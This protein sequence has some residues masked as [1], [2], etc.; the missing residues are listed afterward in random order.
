MLMTK[1]ISDNRSAQIIEIIL[2]PNILV[3]DLESSDSADSLVDVPSFKQRFL[4]EGSIK[5]SLGTSSVIIRLNHSSTINPY[6][7]NISNSLEV[8]T[9]IES[10]SD[11]SDKDSTEIILEISQPPSLPSAPQH[12][13]VTPLTS[14]A[15]YL[16]WSVPDENGG[17]EVSSYKIEYSDENDSDEEWE[18]ISTTKNTFYTDVELI[19][20]TTYYYRVYAV[21][22]EGIGTEYA[23]GSRRTFTDSAPVLPQIDDITISINEEVDIELD[24]AN[25]GEGDI[26]YEIEDLLAGLTFNPET[27]DVSG[28]VTSVSSSDVTYTATD[29]EGDTSSVTFTISAIESVP[30]KVNGLIATARSGTQITLKWNDPTDGGQPISGYKIETSSDEIS[31]TTLAT[32]NGLSYTQLELTHGST[33]YYRVSAVNSLGAGQVSDVVSR[34]THNVPDAPT[35]LL[36]TGVSSTEI[37]LSWI[38]PVNDNNSSIIGYKI[39]YSSDRTTWNTRVTNTKSADVA[40]VDGLLNPE[41]TLY[42]RSICNK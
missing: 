14:T 34:T 25:G 23:F 15:M 1:F 27:R 4:D 10:Y 6:S 2:T 31:W 40:Y 29:E 18:T 17:S 26:T 24:E 9:W 8:E 20:G 12:L 33:H 13:S 5:F 38:T 28:V 11:S 7:F 21:N 35:E 3:I 41:T 16:S 36:A 22:S 37:D 32:H 30:E 42:Y 39:E 19:E